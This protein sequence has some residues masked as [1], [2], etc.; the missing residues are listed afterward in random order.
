MIAITLLVPLTASSMVGV[1]VIGTGFGRRVHIPGL[2]ATQNACVIGVASLRH[3]RARQVAAEFSLPRHFR[4]WRDLIECPEIYAVTIATPPQYHEEIA[5]T[6]LAAEKAVLCEK[7]L[8]MNA[9]QAARM[10][11]AARRASVPHMV[12]FEFR[13]IP[14]WRFAKQLLDKGELGSLR[15]VNVTWTVQS[16]ADSTRPWSWKADRAQGGGILGAL[17]VHVFDYIEW[18]LGPVRSLAAQLSTRVANRPDESGVWKTV[19]SEDCCHVLLELHDQT[20]INIAVSTVAPMGKGHWI[21]CYGEDKV[22]VIGSS[23]LSDYGKGFTVWEGTPGSPHAQEVP[24]PAEYQFEREFSDGRVAPFARVAQRFIDA[25]VKREVDARPSFDDGL[26]AQVLLD[27]AVEA[28]KARRW[29]DVPMIR[30]QR[31]CQV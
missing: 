14:A 16:W 6:A 10:L 15:H 11:E 28:H 23:N 17:G 20:P 1:G 2:L 18:L 12:D 13:E 8:A 30:D 9:A 27:A 24:L 19:D 5:L 29:I 31:D 22:I 26:R 21:E 25:I 4:S 7:P 3:D